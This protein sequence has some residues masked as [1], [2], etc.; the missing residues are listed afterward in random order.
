VLCWKPKLRV[1]ELFIETDEQ[2]KSAG[3]AQVDE[4][5]AWAKAPGAAPSMMREIARTLRIDRPTISLHQG[6]YAQL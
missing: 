3:V 5:A 2:E 1:P 4:L 6:C